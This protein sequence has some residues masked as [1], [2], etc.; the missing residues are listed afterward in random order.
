MAQS[1]LNRLRNRLINRYGQD[2]ESDCCGPRIEE[3]QSDS[4]AGESDSCCK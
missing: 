4:E 2:S 1:V 3:V